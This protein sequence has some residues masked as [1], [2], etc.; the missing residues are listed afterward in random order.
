MAV[1]RALPDLTRT[2]DFL[3]WV[4]EQDYKHEMIEGRL[5][6]MAGG[7]RRHATI[8]VNASA[9]LLAA[10][11]GRPCRPYNSDF[12]VEVDARN[13]Y[14]PDVSVVCDETR[15]FRDRPVL[16]IEVL[17]PTTQ[18][19]DLGP[20]LQNYLKI[21]GLHYVLYLWQDQP[22]ARLWLP[23]EDGGAGP[24]GLTGIDGELDLP[25]LGLKLP[26]AELYRDVDFPA[27]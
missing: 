12:L 24:R 15:D 2:E 23:A 1:A 11:R 14:C 6:M 25:A 26:M 22:R 20:K 8:D 10:L 7:T 27:P 18:R 17:S 3:G 19:E 5:V 16:A 21:A 9:L 13:R 4:W